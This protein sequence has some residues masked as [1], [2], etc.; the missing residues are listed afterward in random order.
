MKEAFESV[1]HTEAVDRTDD[2]AARLGIGQAHG[3]SDAICGRQHLGP[4]AMPCAAGI[5]QDDD[6]PS[7]GEHLIMD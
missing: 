1:L 4:C 3:R 2:D 6:S 7:T 5:G